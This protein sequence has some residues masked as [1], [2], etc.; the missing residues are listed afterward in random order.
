MKMKMIEKI[1]VFMKAL[2]DEYT[3]RGVNAVA[4]VRQIGFNEYLIEEDFCTHKEH[5]IIFKRPNETEVE[6]M[7]VIIT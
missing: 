2:N 6:A 1:N 3:K 7:R 5:H 4:T